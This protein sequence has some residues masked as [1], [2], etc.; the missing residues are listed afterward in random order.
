MNEINGNRILEYQRQ[1][2]IEQ[3]RK[4]YEWQRYEEAKLPSSIK[5]KEL[6]T[7]L[8]I[9]EQFGAVKSLNFTGDAIR[10]VTQMGLNAIFGGALNGRSLMRYERLATAFTT[11]AFTPLDLSRWVSDE[12]FGRQMLNAVNPVVIKR[13]SSIPSNFPVTY[14][15]VKG[16]LVRGISLED[17]MKV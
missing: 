7:D 5:L 10:S 1:S 15:M 9:N 11:P 3:R 8:P 2:Q 14:D 16:S 4:V 6:V 17:E 13:C 12:E